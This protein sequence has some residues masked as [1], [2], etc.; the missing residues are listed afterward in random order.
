MNT[1][2]FSSPSA[3]A[4]SSRAAWV[5]LG[6]CAGLGL[7]VVAFSGCVAT[8]RPARPVAVVHAPPTAIVVKDTPRADAVLIIRDAPP[9]ARREVVIER[10]RP[11]PLHVWVAGHWR[12][13]GRA[14]VW[15]PGHWDKPPRTRAV[16]MAPRWE[17]RGGSYVLIEGSWR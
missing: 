2:L 15:V 6:R 10:D 14:Y 17:H 4:Q 12:H 5:A 1:E 16:W 7:A 11:S 13:D 3:A 8:V 9:P